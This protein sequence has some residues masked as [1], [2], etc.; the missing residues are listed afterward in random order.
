[1]ACDNFFPI[2]AMLC[3]VRQGAFC[4]RN[5]IKNR[6]CKQALTKHAEAL[7]RLFLTYNPSGLERHAYLISAIFISQTLRPPISSSTQYFDSRPI[8]GFHSAVAYIRLST[9]RFGLVEFILVSGD[10]N[11][12]THN[13]TRVLSWVNMIIHIKLAGIS[14]TVCGQF[15]NGGRSTMIWSA[16][17]RFSSV[18]YYTSRSSIPSEKSSNIVFKSF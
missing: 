18:T 12:G 10:R 11:V 2:H 9:W 13:Y 15:Q 8:S 16:V 17:G 4:T 7:P 14:K 6:L 1:M 3:R 5:R